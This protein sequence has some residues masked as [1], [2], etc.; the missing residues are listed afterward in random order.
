MSA[1]EISMSERKIEQKIKVVLRPD[2]ISRKK[3]IGTATK[4][5]YCFV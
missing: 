4:M 5:K 2:F 3:V 1:E